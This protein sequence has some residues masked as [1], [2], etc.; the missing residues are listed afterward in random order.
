M[1]IIYR[2]SIILFCALLTTIL[3]IVVSTAFAQDPPQYG[4]P[5][6]G[7]PDTRD[8]NMYQVHIRPFSA[9]GDLAGVTARL[10]HIKDMGT[11]VIYLMPIFPHGTDQRS[12][13]SPYCIKDFKAV[14]SEYGSL[15]DLRN[16]V[17]GAHSRGMAVILDIAI[18][19]TSWD[20]PW[21]VSHPEYYVRSGN[22]I[23]QLANFSD[24]AA[25][26][27][28]NTG[29]RNAIKDAMRYWIF[30]AN[31]DGYRC[32]FANN[33]PLDFWSDINGD[34]RGISSHDLI[35]MAEGD[36]QENFNVGFDLNFGDRWFWVGLKDI[37]AGSPVASTMQ[38]INNYE[39]ATATGNQE[40]VRYTGNHD[41]YTN[42]NGSHRPFV[43][44]N[45]HDGIVV[46]FLVSAYMK[47]VPMI[48]GGQ[49][50]D[51]E[52]MTPWPWTG[53]KFDWNQNPGA[54][55]DFAEILNFR[56][57]SN[58]IR[59][60]NLTV[61][62]SNDI[63]AFT[64]TA[65]S[66][67]VV[68]I[69][70]LRN[71]SRNYT[72]P[73]ALAGNYSNAYTGTAVNLTSGATLSLGAYE[74]LV[75]TNEDVAPV[76]VTGVSISPTSA[77]INVGA[78][79]QLTANILPSNAT[80]QNVT[81]ASSNPSVATVSNSGLVTGV[82]TGNATMTVTTQDGSR[83][84][85]S[86]IT[87]PQSTSFTVHFYKPA[88]WGT[89]I[90]IYWW[91]TSPSG[92]LADGSWPGVTMNNSGNGWYSHTFTNINSTNLIFNDGSNQTANL[93]RNSTGWYMDGVWYNSQPGNPVPV[94]GVSVS[95]GT[96]T[97]IVNATQQLT[98]TVAPSN[99]SNKTVTWSSNNNAVATVNNNGLV[100]GISSGT[101]LIT[102]TTQDGSRTATANINVPSTGTNTTYYQ[103]QNR[104]QTNRY[105]YDGGNGVV[106][107]GTNPSTTSYQWESVD[108]GNGYFQIKNRATGNIMHV[109]N[110][111]GSIQCSSINPE[112]WSAMW[113]LPD[114]GSG[115]I[116]IQN[117]WQASQRAHIEGLP[118]NV[119][120]A[121]V[122]AGWWSAMWQFQ[123]GVTVNSSMTG[124][125]LVANNMSKT[126][127]L[128]TTRNEI[129]LFPNPSD[130]NLFNVRI[131]SLSGDE[132]ALLTVL[133]LH[134]VTVMTAR[135]NQSTTVKHN[136]APG[137][138]IVKINANGINSTRKLIIE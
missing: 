23:Q 86:A 112:W 69:A 43:V 126:G 93:S 131:S 29:T 100:T 106:S 115:W 67:K 110:Q 55:A 119:Q 51:Y 136:F 77:N 20:H 90:R 135:V 133:D 75:L 5:F 40:V 53:F 4:S 111:N 1:K 88:N 34:L 54:K 71:G 72:I 35:M 62:P 108:L 25:L 102:V 38:T 57:N 73:S 130:D 17:D 89:G 134:G 84:A 14:A 2:R 98:A 80:N 103:I 101:A 24:I 19:G 30:A 59:R 74:Y 65:G 132:T 18:N 109:E 22:T 32:D 36:R 121:G 58:A 78:T 107:Y 26:D 70:N 33:P 60:G 85:T 79:R 3:S 64:K 117:R 63:S 91:A 97:V 104:W 114:A 27:L 15:Q 42:D 47:G 61:Y 11:N 87:V 68:V 83:T 123:N 31:I 92:V 37:A 129:M 7:V 41:S 118:V 50:I 10:D 39:Y 99:A 9:N 95:P 81:W 56:L 44:F 138:Y 125:K 76:A 8:I 12:S 49:E 13:P 120:Y 124:V 137:L 82:S 128:E 21:T 105:M 113:T 52:P 28:N 6:G 66:E 96:S 94:T 45:N 48:M 127:D 116:N 16:L 46:N 122:Q